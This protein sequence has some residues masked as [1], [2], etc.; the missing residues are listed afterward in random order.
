VGLRDT[1]GDK[2][3]T[4]HN[5]KLGNVCITLTFLERSVCHWSLDPKFVKSTVHLSTLDT[6]RPR[7]SPKHIASVT[8]FSRHTCKGGQ[9]NCA[10]ISAYIHR[11]LGKWW[12]VVESKQHPTHRKNQMV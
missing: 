3:T 5:N 1:Q 6:T 9:C 7:G 12:T 8:E 11:V 2:R 10:T 4:L